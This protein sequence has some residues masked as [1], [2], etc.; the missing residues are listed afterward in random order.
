[1]IAGVLGLAAMVGI[2]VRV[3]LPG[4]EAMAEMQQQFAQYQQYDRGWQAQKDEL[5]KQERIAQ[6][7][8]QM[9]YISNE[10][11]RINQIPRKRW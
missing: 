4:D 10:I 8:F 7:D 1:M 11:N 3:T 6:I 2:G 9:R 5:H